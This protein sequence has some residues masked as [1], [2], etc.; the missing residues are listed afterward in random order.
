MKTRMIWILL[1]SMLCLPAPSVL[2]YDDDVQAGIEDVWQSACKLIQPIGIKKMDEKNKKLESKW[3]EDQIVQRNSLLKDITS[4]A[5]RRRYRMK[6]S[7]REAG[8]N[9]HIEVRGE[10][11]KKPVESPPQAPWRKLKKQ[12]EDYDLERDFFMRILAQM[13]KDHG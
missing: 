7:L 2:A 10:F 3:T 6:I 13:A 1:A 9:V 11:E 12:M 8:D 5:Y 4:Q